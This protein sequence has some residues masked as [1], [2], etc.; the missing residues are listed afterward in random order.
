MVFHGV[1]QAVMSQLQQ[2]YGG[3]YTYDNVMISGIHTHAG[4]A[5]YSYLAMYSLTALGFH[6]GNFDAIVGGIVSAITQ[7]HNRLSKGGRV[8][9]NTGELL[10]TNINRSPSA[11]LNNPEEERSQFA[12]NVD[13]LFTLLRMEDQEGNPLGMLSWFSVHGTSMYNTNHLISGDNKGYAAYYTE[14][15]MNGQGSL[16]GIGPFVAAFAQSNEGDVSPNTRGAFCDNGH[17][18]NFAHSTCNGTSENCHGY[19]PGST[20]FES[21]R[22]IGTNQA[23]TA[24]ALWKNAT[25]ALQSRISFVHTFVDM[26]SVSVEPRWTHSGQTEQTCE[27]A[28]GD[29]FAAGTTDGAGDFDF[30]QGTNSTSKN[31]FWNFIGNFLSEPSSAQRACHAPKPILLN[32]G[33]ITF[34]LQW[35]PAILPLQIFRIGDLFLIGVPGE[36]TT[37]SGRRLRATVLQA[38]QA[39]GVANN[40]TLVVIAGLSNAYSQY[41]TTYEEYAI[42]RYEGASTLFGPNTL[43]AYQQLYYGLATALATGTPYP[44]GPTPP[45]LSGKTFSFQPGVIV[46]EPPLFGHFGQVYQDVSSSYTRGQAVSVIFYGANPRNDLRTQDTFLTV[47][48]QVNGQW[49]VVLNDGDWDTKFQWA[50]RYIAESLITITWQIAPNTTPGTY[51]IQHF[52]NSKSLTGKISPYTG[53]SSTFTVS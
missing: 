27:A 53:T 14:K 8:L 30:T 9:I 38:L 49:Q 39:A 23:V 6:K 5:G 31:P 3:L 32:T 51:R 52:G 7:A 44:P 10:D 37:M 25:R 1:R 13:K 40:N 17:P 29:S 18:C 50:R 16:P 47:E 4:P 21:C 28:L 48:Q 36:F 35:T 12:Y 22:I 33:G 11:Y 19:G 15:V 41:I 2:L 43:A 20:D 46:D 45:D 24:L 26:S 42:Q 34:P